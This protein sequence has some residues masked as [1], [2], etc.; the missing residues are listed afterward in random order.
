LT[1]NRSFWSQVFPG[2]PNKNHIHSKHKTNSWQ[3]NL[4]P[5][6]VYLL[7]LPVTKQSG[8]CSY[9]AGAHMGLSLW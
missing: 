2:N 4:H 6:L 5:D 9:N 3:N 7:R 8:P 1:H